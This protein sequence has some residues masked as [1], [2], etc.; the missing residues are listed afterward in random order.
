MTVTD[1]AGQTSTAIATG[2]VNAFGI[3]IANM[4]TVTALIDVTATVIVLGGRI[5]SIFADTLIERKIY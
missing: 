5:E 4:G 2:I 1:V 3:L